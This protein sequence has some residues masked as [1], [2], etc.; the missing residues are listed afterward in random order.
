MGHCVRVKIPLGFVRAE[1]GGCVCELLC[2]CDCVRM[3]VRV[4]M[5]LSVIVIVYALLH[6]R[7]V[8]L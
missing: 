3:C 8:L 4:I 7:D 2:V 5:C 1:G 6:V